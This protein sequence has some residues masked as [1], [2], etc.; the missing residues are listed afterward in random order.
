MKTSVV[1]QTY[2]SRRLDFLEEILALWLKEA[3][4]VF[5]ADCSGGAFATSQPITHVQFNRDVGNKARHALCA[6]TTGDF[7]FLADD[8]LFPGK[9]FM[10]W[11]V[12][13]ALNFEGSIVGLI[14]RKFKTDNYYKGN[15]FCKASNINEPVKVDFCSHVLTPR[16]Y[17]GFDCLGCDNEIEDLFWHMKHFSLAPKYVVPCTNYRIMKDDDECLFHNP[18]AREKRQAFY[19]KYFDMYYKDRSL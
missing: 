9:G 1:I 11:M 13:W 7:V 8:D 10:N 19:K 4:E 12:D 14:G 5:L 15:P 6:L 2:K 3:D 18:E 16:T 17:I